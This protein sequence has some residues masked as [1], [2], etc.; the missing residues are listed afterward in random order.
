L[1]VLAALL[2]IIDGALGIAQMYLSSKIGAGIVMSLRAKL[3]EHIQ[4]MPLAF[5]TRTCG[6]LSRRISEI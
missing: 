4:Q 5:F 6:E 3:F 1:A 2:G